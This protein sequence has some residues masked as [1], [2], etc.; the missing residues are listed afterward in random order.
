MA[1]E[2]IIVFR[3]FRKFSLSVA[4]ATDQRQ[5]FGQNLC[6]VEDFSI[7]IS[8]KNANISATR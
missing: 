7:N 4:M 6:L 5:R 1:S 8:E 2:E 3:S